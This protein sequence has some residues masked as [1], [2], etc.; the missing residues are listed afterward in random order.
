MANFRRAGD[1]PQYQKWHK[2]FKEQQEQTELEKY[3]DR[4][5]NR[6]AIAFVVL[7]FVGTLIYKFFGA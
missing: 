6:M 3:I 5:L 1:N 4:V 2:R 7:F